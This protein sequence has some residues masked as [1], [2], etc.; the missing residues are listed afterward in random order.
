M[1]GTLITN[2]SNLKYITNKNYSNMFVIITDSQNHLFTDPRYQHA[3]KECPEFKVWIYTNLKETIQ[4]FLQE[5]PLSEIHF[6]SM[7]ITV[8]KLKIFKKIFKKIKF[9]ELKQNPILEQRKIKSQEEIKNIRESQILNEK[10]YQE[11]IKHLKPGISELEIANIIKTKAIQSN[12]EVSFEPIVG[13]AEN[14]A[15]IHHSPT[16]KKY[17]DGDCVLIDMGVKFKDYCSD[18]TRFIKSKNKDY[19]KHYEFLKNLI[20]KFEENFKNFKTLEDIDR[21]ARAEYKKLNNI[22]L[23]HSLG[24]GIGI[25]VH[26]KPFFGEKTKIQDGLVFTIEPGIYIPEKYGIRLENIYYI[27]DSKLINCN[28]LEV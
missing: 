22:N 8:G 14:S 6:E 17:K 15:N 26:E 7:D 27:K 19:L 1:K 13:F 25:E 2:K 23:P 20:N 10:I 4:E 11:A 16:S 21:F 24:H 3:S 28:T 5:N 12:S 18:M 9:K